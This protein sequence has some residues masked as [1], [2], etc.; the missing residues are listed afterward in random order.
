MKIPKKITV[1]LKGVHRDEVMDLEIWLNNAIYE[2]PNFTSKNNTIIIQPKRLEDALKTMH[3][4]EKNH[5]KWEVELNE[6][7]E[8]TWIGIDINSNFGP[9]YKYCIGIN[10]EQGTDFSVLNS[11]QPDNAWF[12]PH[13]E[14]SV[15]YGEKA[16]VFDDKNELNK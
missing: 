13:H 9:N 1:D 10:L 4:L 2:M 16:R 8:E 12:I 5:W 11:L 15:K 6:P 7:K 14:I 3:Y